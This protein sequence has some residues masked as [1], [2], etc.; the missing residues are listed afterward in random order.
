MINSI[1]GLNN[2]YLSTQN[3][4][5][6]NEDRLLFDR[7]ALENWLIYENESMNK[8]KEILKHSLSIK[9]K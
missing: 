7:L 6:K 4:N 5:Y 2:P 9:T 3:E 1:F 8:L